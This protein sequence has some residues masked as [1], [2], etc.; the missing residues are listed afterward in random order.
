MEKIHTETPNTQNT[1]PTKKGKPK[2]ANNNR[3]PTRKELYM[4]DRLPE[5]EMDNDDNDGGVRGRKRR[6]MQPQRG[7]VLIDRHAPH[8]ELWYCV[9]IDIE[10]EGTGEDEEDTCNDDAS[11]EVRETRGHIEALKAALRDKHRALSETLSGIGGH[12][13]QSFMAGIHGNR[14]VNRQ[15][16]RCSI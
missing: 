8:P 2:K 5:E 12:K 11:K 10:D 3:Q 1:Q 4:G 14:E 13:S 16:Y 9:N 15:Q 7:I 6:R